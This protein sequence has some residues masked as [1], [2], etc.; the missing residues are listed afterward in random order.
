MTR[1]TIVPYVPVSTSTEDQTACAAV[2]MYGVRNVGWSAPIHRNNRPS[3][4]IA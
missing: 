3:S 4:A 1:D 2:A